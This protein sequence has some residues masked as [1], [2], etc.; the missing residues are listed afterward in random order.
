M[1]LKEQFND[2]FRSQ[3]PPMLY[4]M[5]AVSSTAPE[6]AR[7][8]YNRNFGMTGPDRRAQLLEALNWSVQTAEDSIFVLPDCVALAQEDGPLFESL[9]LANLD[10]AK[11]VLMP[12]SSKKMLV[13]LK[14]GAGK[15][16]LRDF[17]IAAAA[18]SHEY[19][20]ASIESE[21]FKALQ[22]FDR[23]IL[24]EICGRRC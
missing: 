10:T 12:L 24:N 11:A 15:P 2:F 14:E 6:L 4:A 13:G 7:E 8:S 1:T 20:L 16:Q 17:N 3:L 21:Q 18:C 19:F 23:S 22:D 9:I 5:S